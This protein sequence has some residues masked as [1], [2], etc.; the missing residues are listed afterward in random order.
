[1]GSISL[2]VF[3]LFNLK[4]D[5]FFII[6]VSDIPVYN[7]RVYKYGISDILSQRNDHVNQLFQ[8]IV[9]VK[10]KNVYYPFICHMLLQV[11]IKPTLK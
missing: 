2:Y 4:G 11:Q 3:P 8:L 10:R 7:N 5:F 1:M 6:G 9:V